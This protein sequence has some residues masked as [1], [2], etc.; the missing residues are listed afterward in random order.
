[1]ITPNTTTL[2]EREIVLTA[3][4]TTTPVPVA[5]PTT[6]PVPMQYTILPQY[7]QVVSNGVIYT[8]DLSAYMVLLLNMRAIQIVGNTAT[9]EYITAG[10]GNDI[11]PASTFQV[12]IDQV[13]LLKHPVIVPPTLAQAQHTAT[14][15][16]FNSYNNQLLNGFTTNGIKMLA[17]VSEIQLLQFLHDFAVKLNQSTIDVIDY[18]NITHPGISI[19]VV[20]S[21]ITDLMIN[22]QTLTTKKQT[23]TTQIN[24]ATTVSQVNAVV[25]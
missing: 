16:I 23:L 20:D 6:T 14:I 5:I 12:I 18:N 25:W 10:T 24:N 13:E 8:L 17:D 11:V 3:M 7:N 19:T 1:M 22:Y 2:Y 21:M 9:I 15:S 4:P